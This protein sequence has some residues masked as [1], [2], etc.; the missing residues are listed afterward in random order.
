MH[1]RPAFLFARSCAQCIPFLR[2]FF[3]PHAH[4]FLLT[5]RTRWHAGTNLQAFALAPLFVW[6]ELLFLLGYRPTLRH[7][8]QAQVDQLIAAHR[9]KKQPLVNSAEQQ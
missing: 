8:L 7:E 1:T 6:Y 2:N 5:T 4:A 9:A 3:L